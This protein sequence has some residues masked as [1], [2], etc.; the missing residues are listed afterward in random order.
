[1]NTL[2]AMNS[3]RGVRNAQGLPVRGQNSKSNARTQRKRRRVTP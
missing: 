2:R 1:M 3:Y